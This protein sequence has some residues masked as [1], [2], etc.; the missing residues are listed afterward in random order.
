MTKDQKW[1]AEISV[2]GGRSKTR[3]DPSVLGSAE[4]GIE[5]QH[6]ASEHSDEFDTIFPFPMNLYE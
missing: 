2:Q 4:L 6:T 1:D 5:R 3:R